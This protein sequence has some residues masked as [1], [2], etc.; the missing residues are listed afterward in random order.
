MQGATGQMQGATGQMQGVSKIQF[1]REDNYNF[2]M[3][4]QR[5]ELEC[6]LEGQW[7]YTEETN[8]K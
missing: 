4:T 7:D 8:P 6:N 1:V 5:G 2:T 3:S